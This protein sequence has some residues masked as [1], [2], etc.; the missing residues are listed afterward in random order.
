MSRALSRSRGGATD[1]HS[2]RLRT[3]ELAALALVVALPGCAG[4]R[5]AANSSRSPREVRTMVDDGTTGPAIDRFQYAGQWSHVT[6]RRDGRTLGTS[7]RSARA[8]DAA[9]I[10]FAGTRIRLY[11]VLGDRGG[12]GSMQLDG[13][14]AGTADFYA[15]HVAGNALVF[16]SSELAPGRHELVVSV[17]G[18]RDPASGGNYVNVDGAVVTESEQR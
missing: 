9:T 4:A 12:V 16:E 6:A 2:L 17:A 1:V 18:A 14:P 7:S 13:Q 5:A 3:L 8:G 11:G 10:S 15:P